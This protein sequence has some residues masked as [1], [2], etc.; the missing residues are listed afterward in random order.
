M[1]PMLRG[2]KAAAA[3]VMLT[4]WETTAK[5]WE[6]GLEEHRTRWG[7]RQRL[8][9]ARRQLTLRDIR[10]KEM[11]A[12]AAEAAAAAAAAAA[13]L[14]A[15]GL[16]KDEELL[17]AAGDDAADRDEDNGSSPSKAEKLAG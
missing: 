8:Q 7:Q 3:T 16:K 2:G 14:P 15:D 1:L 13:A 4:A 6:V 10:I 5:K 9:Q 17:A 12:T 11:A